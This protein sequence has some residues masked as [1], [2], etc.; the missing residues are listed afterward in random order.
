MEAGGHLVNETGDT[1]ERV[2]QSVREVRDLIGQIA[3]AI[4]SQSDSVGEVNTAIAQLD[5][6]TQ[7]NA[8]LVEESA[9]AAESL[10]Q[11]AG[12][13]QEAVT[14]F[15]VGVELAAS[16][17]AG[18]HGSGWLPRRAGI[19]APFPRSSSAKN[20]RSRPYAACMFAWPIS[21]VP[22]GSGPS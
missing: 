4:H 7:Q 9:A 15:S 3:S 10:K 12:E 6:M 5:G 11:Q 8:V 20:R 14:H 17:L 18:P 13:L 21:F 1:M 16:R 19:E 22:A 2:V